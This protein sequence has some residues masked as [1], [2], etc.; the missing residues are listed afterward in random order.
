MKPEGQSGVVVDI[1][2]VCT[3][4][5]VA[6]VV[7]VAAAVV[8]AVVVGAGVVVVVARDAS[9]AAVLRALPPANPG[10]VAAW[11]AADPS[12]ARKR[13]KM[14]GNK[15][16][17]FTEAWVEFMNKA[18]AQRVARSLNARPIGGKKSDFFA[19]DLWNMKYLKRFK[20]SDLT[21]R[22]GACASAAVW[23][24]L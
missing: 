22:L 1:V 7:A 16:G 18:L 23:G 15:K 14:G 4:L 24:C 10:S 20:W 12:I 2:F 21:E 11:H 13:K 3:T 17:S 6:I 8:A 19:S 9:V 5:T